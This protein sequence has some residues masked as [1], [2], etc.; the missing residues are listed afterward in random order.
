MFTSVVSSADVDKASQAALM[1]TGLGRGRPPKSA[2]TW[3]DP[4]P[5]GKFFPAEPL[6]FPRAA[7][8]WPCAN[9]TFESLAQRLA[10]ETIILSSFACKTEADFEAVDWEEDDIEVEESNELADLDVCDADELGDAGSFFRELPRMQVSQGRDSLHASG[11]RAL[12]IRE[13]QDLLRR[14]TDVARDVKLR[15]LVPARVLKD[16]GFGQGE[17]SLWA[18]PANATTGLHADLDPGNFLVHIGPGRKRVVALPAY[19]AEVLGSRYAARGSYPPVRMDLFAPNITAT[20]PHL[21]ALRDHPHLIATVLEPNDVLYIPCGWF[22]QIQYIEEASVSV[23][24]IIY[25]VDE[26][27]DFTLQDCGTHI[28]PL[29]SL[30]P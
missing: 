1:M 4:P 9:W 24:V 3:P 11:I 23:N 6:L 26:P 20:F 28:Q 18:G 19:C 10:N 29:E 2:E 25:H 21:N 30:S 27:Q 8:K 13:N 14:R 22:H 16:G 17:A 7:S 15:Q 12:M 5:G